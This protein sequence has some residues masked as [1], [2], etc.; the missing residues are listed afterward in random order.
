MEPLA[1]PLRSPESSKNPASIQNPF[2]TRSKKFK[3]CLCVSVVCVSVTFFTSSKT[4][5]LKGNGWGKKSLE[6]SLSEDFISS[7]KRVFKNFRSPFHLVHLTFNSPS[8][9]RRSALSP[10]S[11][12]HAHQRCQA[13][14]QARRGS[15]A[16]GS[17]RVDMHA[18]MPG[19]VRPI[20]GH[21]ILQ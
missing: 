4:R 10:E 2:H 7:K 16:P 12:K 15:R 20:Y 1:A 21:G 3:K 5:F 17:G 11:G 8:R 18:C 9:D 14:L 13:D 6:K 19:T